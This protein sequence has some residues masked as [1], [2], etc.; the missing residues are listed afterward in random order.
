MDAVTRSWVSFH[1]AG[2]QRDD[3]K[4]R[5]ERP[6]TRTARGH[7]A[8]RTNPA[9][10]SG[11]GHATAL[12]PALPVLRHTDDQEPQR[13]A[14]PPGRRSPSV[15]VPLATYAPG[16]SRDDSQPNVTLHHVATGAT[17]HLTQA[18]GSARSRPGSATPPP[19]GGDEIRSSHVPRQ[20][21]GHREANHEK[22]HPKRGVRA[23]L[24]AH[25]ALDSVR[26]IRTSHLSSACHAAPL[27]RAGPARAAIQGEGVAGERHGNRVGVNGK[28]LQDDADLVAETGDAPRRLRPVE[29]R[30][31]SWPAGRLRG[32]APASSRPACSPLPGPGGSGAARRSDPRPPIPDTVNPLPEPSATRRLHTFPTTHVPAA[33]AGWAVSGGV[34]ATHSH[35]P[36]ANLPPLTTSAATA[37]QHTPSSFD[38]VPFATSPSVVRWLPA[39][40]AGLP[41]VARLVAPAASPKVPHAAAHARALPIHNIGAD[42]YAK[43]S[44]TRRTQHR[45]GPQALAADAPC[46]TPCHPAQ[47]VL[48]VLPPPWAQTRTQHVATSKWTSG[49][50]RTMGDDLGTTLETAMTASLSCLIMALPADACATMPSPIEDVDARGEGAGRAGATWGG[51]VR[52]GEPPDNGTTTMAGIPSWATAGLFQLLHP[53]LFRTHLCIPRI[54]AIHSPPSTPTPA[55]LVRSDAPIFH[56][57]LV[58]TIVVGVRRILSDP[59]RL[60]SSR[61]P[62]LRSTPRGLVLVMPRLDRASRDGGLQQVY[63]VGGRQPPGGADSLTEVTTDDEGG[64]LGEAT[65]AT[66]GH[67]RTCHR[68]AKSRFHSHHIWLP[69]CPIPRQVTPLLKGEATPA[70]AAWAWLTGRIAAA[71]GTTKQDRTACRAAPNEVRATV[72]NVLGAK[73]LASGRD[74]SEP[75]LLLPSTQRLTTHFSQQS[76]DLEGVVPTAG[77]GVKTRE[78]MVMNGAAFTLAAGRAAEGRV[79][80]RGVARERLPH[81][82]NDGKQDEHR[83]GPAPKAARAS[84]PPGSRAG[85]R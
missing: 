3:E 13:L 55:F 82:G 32:A 36:A 42:K 64:L 67:R 49:L 11:L 5:C 83:T 37:P 65:V 61:T 34:I 77:V 16:R 68:R 28:Q 17:S 39:G 74:D 70:W 12:R 19:A 30:T 72:A 85:R 47:E 1:T 38:G 26:S 25:E 57:M 7:S 2:C 46:H 41:R 23:V 84:P 48:H 80:G 50:V 52:E 33:V 29:S 24:R 71:E 66:S 76:D 15:S 27:V 45:P 62:I 60:P 43:W 20:S 54:A 56:P 81:A 10:R 75:L 21:T 35:P 8:T 73:S 69:P 18:E 14:P 53:P 40:A 44:G 9:V 59:P 58:M 78:V 63:G 4:Q 6:H 79:G 51:G 22:L 31:G